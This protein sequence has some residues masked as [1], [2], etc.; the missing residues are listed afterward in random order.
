MHLVIAQV[1]ALL[2]S[3]VLLFGYNKNVIDVEEGEGIKGEYCE[4]PPKIASARRG[5]Q[6]PRLPRQG[7][8]HD[9][10]EREKLRLCECELEHVRMLPHRLEWWYACAHGYHIGHRLR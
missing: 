8:E 10:C 9:A 7:P 2:T 4:E 1:G 3:C 5:P 6:G